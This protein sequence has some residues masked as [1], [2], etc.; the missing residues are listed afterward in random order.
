MLWSQR[1][2]NRAHGAENSIQISALAGVGPWHLAAADVATRLPRTP[3]FSRLLRHAGGYSRIILTPNLDLCKENKYS[4]IRQCR[5]SEKLCKTDLVR[6]R[7][8]NIGFLG[9]PV[10][11][12]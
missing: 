12:C 10:F 1:R 9:K 6:T 8:V 3:P 7:D 11:G 4:N 5:V 2:N